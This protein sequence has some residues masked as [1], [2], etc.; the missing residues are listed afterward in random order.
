[1]KEKNKKRIVVALAV[2]LVCSVMAMILQTDFGRVRI[3]DITLETSQQ[4]QLHAL[5]F[6]PKNASANNK[7][8]VIIT[9]HSGFYTAE[10]QD[11]A[12]IE[13]SRRGVCVI[14]IDA[15]SHG[16]S[17]NVPVNLVTSEMEEG[18]GI[19][20]MV[21]YAAS[22][23][24]D[25][26][27]TD[28]IGVMGHSMGGRSVRATLMHYGELYDQ[29]MEA[30]ARED[31]EKG[32]EITENEL[33]LAQKS[34]KINAAL[35][36]GITPGLMAENW[37][38]VHCN[39]GIVYGQLEEGG[40]ANST[41]NAR[42]LGATD[43]ALAM[44]HS[45]DESVSSVEEGRFYGDLE[46]GTLRVLSQ[47]K[48][49][50]LMGPTAPSATEDA[51]RYWTK[52]WAL[53]SHL[54]P[55]D[56]VYLIKELFNLGA[57]AALL[58]LV[59]PFGD[60]LLSCP[61][62]TPLRASG[63]P[64][65]RAMSRKK[66]HTGAVLGMAVS[67]LAGMLTELIDRKGWI[68]HA[69]PFENARIFPANGMNI[70]I[71]W[72]FILT[73]W[74]FIWYYFC[75]RPL[76]S[77]E[78]GKKEIWRS[79]LL[80]VFTVGLVYGVVWFC[81]WMFNTDFRFWTQCIKSFNNEKLLYFLQYFPFFFLFLLSLSMAVNSFDTIEGCSE[82]RT[83]HLLALGGLLGWAILELAQYGK[84][85]LTGSVLWTDWNAISVIF[86]LGWQLFLAPYFL[87][88]FYRLTG[89]NWAGALTVSGLYTM[90]GITGTTIQSAML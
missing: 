5:A 81:K 72:L 2:I 89:K 6:S 23:I 65:G 41:G 85:F 77:P 64:G 3:R 52:V 36:T 51:I 70:A 31:S 20:P 68:F 76:K 21:E 26:V 43:E 10:F 4:Q 12:S 15:Y 63:L 71:T 29:A 49:T 13:L 78:G 60:M 19:I 39:T 32:A 75:S 17:S 7:I 37:D 66:Y 54:T 16:F 57:M 56:Q 22:G 84:L 53:D 9:M 86:F 25:F 38:L 30:A 35:A 88:G 80:A 61:L 83:L 27:D 46:E 47:P 48:V 1:M 74:N 82:E 33:A 58:S 44:V 40:Y 18:C 34:Y 42:L 14:A 62:F 45:V 55:E 59:V 69:T 28:R 8:P 87:R 73:V 24:L 11:A 79:I 90:I 67:V 50:H